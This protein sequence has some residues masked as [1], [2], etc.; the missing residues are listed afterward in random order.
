MKDDVQQVKKAQQAQQRVAELLNQGLIEAGIS[1]ARALGEVFPKTADINN[2]LG[3]VEEQFGDAERALKAYSECIRIQPSNPKAY[4]SLG[5]LCANLQ[6][7]TDAI[8]LFSFVLDMAPNWFT[9]PKSFGFS[10]NFFNKLVYAGR[11]LVQFY[12]Q[13]HSQALTENP[14]VQRIA[15]A[16]WPQTHLQPFDYNTPRQMP[17]LFYIPDLTAVPIWDVSKFTWVPDLIAQHSFIK[18]ELSSVITQ[19]DSVARP[20]LDNHFSAEDF[21]AL[22]GKQTWTAL[23]LYKEGELSTFAKQYFP[24]TIEILSTLPLAARGGL[25]DEVFFS[26]LKAGQ[27]IPPHYGLSN[28]SLTCHLGIDVPS[29]CELSVGDEIYQWQDAEVLVFDDTFIHS[30]RNNSSHTR[31]VLLFSIWHPD[32]SEEEVQAIKRTFN[33][34]QAWLQGRVVPSFI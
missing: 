18:S 16:I 21:E 23:D 4:I 28:H 5:Y 30:A 32:L 34:R 2:F 26:I 24:K 22:A 25:P 11:A 6:K 33:S 15:S 8:V 29:D 17:H 1:K 3:N 10:E 27:E 19:L 20:Y 9:Q 14:K 12:T 7:H 31:I 13:Q